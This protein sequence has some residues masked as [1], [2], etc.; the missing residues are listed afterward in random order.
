ML[1]C[2][3]LLCKCN[4]ALMCLDGSVNR[5]YYKDTLDK[6]SGSKSQRGKRSIE[7]G[8]DQS[9][10]K[11]PRV[12][13][14]SRNSRSKSRSASLGPSLS[15]A[16]TT[17]KISLSPAV[18]DFTIPEPTKKSKLDSS[19]TIWKNFETQLKIKP[20]I[21]DAIDS[22]GKSCT[23][24]KSGN[25]RLDYQNTV[26]EK[27][28]SI[29]MPPGLAATVE[30]AKNF[31]N[32]QLQFGNESYACVLVELGIKF[33]RHKILDALKLSYNQKENVYLCRWCKEQ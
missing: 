10:R 32:I 33:G 15:P 28:V 12:D 14:D 4:F 29:I 6:M 13:N 2:G 20:F 1:G 23:I 26:P 19:C 5:A 27:A 24:W 21:L 9:G 16:V 22:R 18:I 7:D 17:K 3:L 8:D 25:L 31:A 11:C 30:V